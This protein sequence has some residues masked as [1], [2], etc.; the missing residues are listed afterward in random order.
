MLRLRGDVTHPQPGASAGSDPPTES[1][2]YSD[3]VLGYRLPGRVSGTP[4][5]R[6]GVYPA[7]DLVDAE[8]EQRYHKAEHI[9]YEFCQSIRGGGTMKF[10]IRNGCLRQPWEKVFEIAGDIGFDGVELDIGADYKDT[11]LWTKEGRQQ[12]AEWASQGAELCSTCIGGLWTHSFGDADP[13]VRAAAQEVT[14]NTIEACAELGARWIL[15]P[16]TPGKDVTEEEGIAHWIE[17]VKQCAPIA[18]KHQVILALENVGRGYAQ[19]AEGLLPIATSV[20]S[21]YVRTYYDFG[22]G[23]SLGNDPIAEIKLLGSEWIAIIHAKDPGGQLLGEG[24]IDFDAVE[25]AI[26]E[27]GYDGYMV[28]ETPATEDPI[29]AAKHNLEFLQKRFG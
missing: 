25:A 20:D 24:R 15:V 26:D 14:T 3:G 11:L 9:S 13:D 29:A 7:N 19:S 1:L 4:C 8:D 10:G 21:P 23:L 17:G 18:E 16:I 2:R 12:V 27:I 22:N 28:L 6:D 5:H